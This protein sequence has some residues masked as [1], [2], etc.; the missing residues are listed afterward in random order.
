MSNDS[1]TLTVIGGCNGSG[2]S[3]YSQFI[4]ENKPKPFDYDLVFLEH[5]KSLIPNDLQGRM[6]H[7]LARQSLLYEVDRSISKKTDFAFETNF[8]STPLHWP[9]LFKSN[10]YK[11]RLAYFCLD[12]IEEAERRVQIRVENGGHYVPKNEINSRFYLGYEHLNMHWKFF[13]EVIL[14]NTSGYKKAPIPFAQI[15]AG[16]INTFESFPVFLEN[17]LPS[18]K[19]LT[20]LR[21]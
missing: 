6:A 20:E 1:P 9:K 12:S 21:Q 2:K 11:L 19:V 4:T 8:N 10:G 5:Y 15:V 16:R 3:T 13:N 7:N 18:I 14:F 17:L